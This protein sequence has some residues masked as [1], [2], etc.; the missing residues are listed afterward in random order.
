MIRPLVLALCAS[1]VLAMPGGA[2]SAVPGPDVT[3]LP[4]GDDPHLVWM[5][6]RDVHRADGEVERLPFSHGDEE[7][8]RLLGR[9]RGEWIVVDPGVTT[10]VVGVRDG[11]AR[12]FWK[13]T[14]YEPA[15]TYALSR[16][17]N[18]VVQWYSDR[19]G[20]TTATVFGLS[21]KSLG[22]H[23]WYQWG[24]VLDF[25]DNTLLLGF[26]KTVRWRAGTA[27]VQVAGGAAMVDRAHDLLF[28]YDA[29]FNAGP[30]SLAAPGTPAWTAPFLPRE[31]S[32][33]GQWVAGYDL[34][35]MSKLQVRSVADGSLQAVSGLRLAYGAELA[36]EP[37]GRLLAEVHSA[38]GNA[39]LRCTVTVA[40]D[41]RATDWSKG[42]ELSFPY[43]PQYFGEY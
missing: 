2:A 9:A 30:T 7:Y 40:C 21:G 24:D 4:R 13:R 42:M 31:V 8:L 23:S 39:L 6:G 43:Q 17:G 25:S 12:V 41:E 33:D 15:T 28:A 19:G 27:P 18:Q 29:E 16:G 26:R 1:Y 36:F 3:T 38:K 5:V 11:R 34:K 22:K 37:D 35:T 32:P 20:S 10:R 14:Y